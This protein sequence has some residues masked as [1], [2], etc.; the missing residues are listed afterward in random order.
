MLVKFLAD[1][2]HGISVVQDPKNRD[3]VVKIMSEL[4]GRPAAAFASWA[5]LPGKDF[6][7]DPH[8]LVNVKA[9]QSNID[10]LGRAEDDAE[11]FR[12]EPAR[13]QF[14]GQGRAQ[15]HVRRACKVRAIKKAALA[16]RA[17]AY[18]ASWSAR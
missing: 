7:H 2:V 13:R 17:A 16:M 12:R 5:L 6:Y 18:F 9:L 15:E 14:A 4:T 8:G 1:Y 11:G 10:T 3:R